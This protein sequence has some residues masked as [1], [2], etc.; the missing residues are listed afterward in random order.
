MNTNTMN[1]ITTTTDDN[2]QVRS[3]LQGQIKGCL[4]AYGVQEWLYPVIH[5]ALAEREEIGEPLTDSEQ[6]TTE[7]ALEQLRETDWKL[8]QRQWTEARDYMIQ[9][10]D[11]LRDAGVAM[12]VGAGWRRELDL[13]ITDLSESIDGAMIEPGSHEWIT[14][15]GDK[16]CPI[17]LDQPYY[18]D[19][20][21]EA[22]LDMWEDG[23]PV[24]VVDGALTAEI[25]DEY[26]D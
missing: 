23:A 2:D 21:L 17:L 4:Q 8:G 25:D 11:A 20:D 10:H 7:R 13:Q 14:W 1:T 24:S 5:D 6:E 22:V 19:S 15:R 3:W 12:E 16:Y 18:R 9:A 26:E